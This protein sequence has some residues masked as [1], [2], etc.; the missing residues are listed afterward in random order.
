MENDLRKSHIEL[1][2]IYFWTAS[3]HLHI[4]LLYHEDACNIILNSLSYLSNKKHLSVFAFVIM[5]THVHFIWK[6]ESKNGK[7]MP[8]VSFLKY[9]AHQFKSMLIPQPDELL[10]FQVNAANKK[11]EFWQRDSLA[12]ELYSPEIIFQKLDY[13]HHNP[14][15]KKWNL[16][17]DFTLYPYSSAS[18]YEKGESSFTFLKDIRIELDGE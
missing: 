16:T 9:T 12:I 3:I 4:P 14:V 7:E 5:P 2:S 11:F 10:K 17:D 8:H 15:S 6:A 18:F 13:I 1:G